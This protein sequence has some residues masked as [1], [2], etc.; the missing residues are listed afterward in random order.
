MLR[1]ACSLATEREIQVCAPVHDAQLIEDSVDNIQERVAATQAAM[2][3]ASELVLDGF[4][5]R[6]DA[7]IVLAPERYMDRRGEKMGERVMGLL[8]SE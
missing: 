5:L 3:M 2:Q 1:L 6:S 7:K 4:A 8:P